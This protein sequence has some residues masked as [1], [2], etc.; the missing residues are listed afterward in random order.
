MSSQSGTGCRTS[1]SSRGRLCRPRPMPTRSHVASQALI[2][3]LVRSTGAADAPGAVRMKARE[4]INLGVSTFDDAT[5][6]PDIDVLASLRGIARSDEPP[7][8]SPD[9]ELVPD[10]RSGV[11]MWVNPDLLEMLCDVGAAEPLF[12]YPWFPAHAAA[13][14]SAAGLAQLAADYRA[15]REATVRRYAEVSQGA[16]AAVFFAWKLK[17]TQK[18]TIGRPEQPNLLGI[19]PAEEARA[20]S[21]LRIEYMVASA[22]LLAGATSCRKTSPSRTMGRSTR[23][24]RRAA[25]ATASASWTWA[26]RPAS[27]AC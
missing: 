7:V 22:G 2:D 26:R 5:K 27:T 18:R 11:A 20:A 6:P 21:R 19:A 9:A 1:L 24:W 10:G 16:V 8:Y 3:E 14:N 12:A 15:S 13:V 23:P 17:P 25:P 4:L